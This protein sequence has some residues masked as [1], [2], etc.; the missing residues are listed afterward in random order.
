MRIAFEHEGAEQK[1]AVAVSFDL[2]GFSKF[3]TH[4]ESRRFIQPLIASMFDTLNECFRPMVDFSSGG[5]DSTRISAPD[6]AKYSGDG[7]LLLWFV[8]EEPQQLPLH[9]PQS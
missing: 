4:P 5:A 3:C 7:A 1:R 2:T 9:A 6:F 8:P